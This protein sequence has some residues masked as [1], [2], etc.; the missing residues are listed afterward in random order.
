[1]PSKTTMGILQKR[2]IIGESV[3][4]LCSLVALFSLVGGSSRLILILS[5]MNEPLIYLHVNTHI[6]GNTFFY[7]LRF[8]SLQY[9]AVET[10]N[11][12]I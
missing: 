4:G 6:E 11:R 7:I 10:A 9:A 5:I 8:Y 3:V 12:K 2:L 1:M